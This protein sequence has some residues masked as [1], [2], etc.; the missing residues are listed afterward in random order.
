MDPEYYWWVMKKGYEKLVDSGL[1]K[2][3]KAS[4]SQVQN[5][6]ELAKRDINT[7][8]ATMAHDRDWAFSIAYN[9]ILQATRALMFN[10]GFRPAA[11]EGQHKAAVQFAE[12]LLGDQFGEEIH[13]FD[14]MRSKRHR[15]VYDVSGLISQAEARQAFAF[16]VKYVEMIKKILS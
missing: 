3:F 9:A 15:V 16:A 6:L 10:E 12:V 1:I 2:P 11:G 8:R 4:K 7:A 13:V 14:K 5:R